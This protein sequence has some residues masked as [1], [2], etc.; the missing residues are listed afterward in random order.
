MH[1]DLHKCEI[2]YFARHFDAR[3]Y[4][5]VQELGERRNGVGERRKGWEKGEEDG[6]REKKV[7]RNE[8]RV[9]EGRQDPP[10]HPH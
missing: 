8:K 4:Q 2:K 5:I 1:R 9:G 3:N 7:W 10:V 6:R